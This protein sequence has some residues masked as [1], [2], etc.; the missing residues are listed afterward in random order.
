MQRRY[1]GSIT[2]FAALAI[3]LV[4]QLLFTLIEEARHVEFK[5]I[6]QMNTDSVLESIFA[7]YC[8]PLWDEYHLLGMTTENSDG[9]LSTNNR[10]AQMRKLTQENL[11]DSH[12]NELFAGIN[13]FHADLV[14]MN[15]DFYLL[16]TDGGGS[17]FE[18]AISAYMK[19]NLAYELA[20]GIYNNFESI[21]D[22]QDQYGDGSD[23]IDG[24]LDALEEAKKESEEA[25][26]KKSKSGVKTQSGVTMLGNAV[27]AQSAN[28][29]K[30]EKKS[31]EENPLTTVTEA[32]KSGILSLVLPS[33]AHL[34]GAAFTSEARVSKRT[35]AQGT[36]E[37]PSDEDWYD[38][39]LFTQYVCNYMSSYTAPIA[40]R[41][42][43]YEMEYLIGGKD[44]D[45]DN[46]R[47]TVDRLLLVREGLNMASLM[48]MPDK[49]AEA[50][51]LAVTLAGA[52]VNPLIIEAVKYGILAAWAYV[53]SVLDVRALL[54]GDK[55]SLIKSSATW[56][57]TIENFPTL[58]SGWSKARSCDVG[59]LNYMQYGA[60]LLLFE[61]GKTLAMR[62]MD[63]QEAT[64]RTVDGYD[65]FR[66]DH[67]V[68]EMQV[69]AA[70]EYHPV[71]TAFVS[72]LKNAP[73]YQRIMDDATY[74]YFRGKEDV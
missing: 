54:D 51:T 72:M 62:A 19:E 66:M 28:R 21:K 46:L 24:A 60:S 16:M 17:V 10:S 56:T 14:D 65:K 20:K 37:I 74:S 11:G 39:T 8:G 27:H 26:E 45:A 18:Q 71:F 6:V 48:A 63:A 44:N 41:A 73:S 42:L 38:E 43:Q 13:L 40:D 1:R 49:Q 33:E 70:Y 34:S 53:E 64:V 58:L 2:V 35:L 25:A 23:K 32:Q 69:Q 68:C 5:K 31:D 50:M 55:I 47:V 12:K 7:D 15:A 30:T 22:S 61:S 29:A 3:M 36:A 57:S 52:T 4:A 9:E 59:G 67:V